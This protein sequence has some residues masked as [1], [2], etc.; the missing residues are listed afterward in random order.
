MKKA[1]GVQ[2]QRLDPL[3]KGIRRNKYDI[4]N[5]CF[6]NIMVSFL[7]YPFYV[8]ALSRYRVLETTNFIYF[9]IPP[10]FVS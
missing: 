10:F 7:L 6:V 3:Q 5:S 4:L 1:G 8:K 2:P 9:L